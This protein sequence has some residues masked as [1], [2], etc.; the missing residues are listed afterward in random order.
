MSDNTGRAFSEGEIHQSMAAGLDM[1]IP[2]DVRP[3]TSPKVSGVVLAERRHVNPNAVAERT[4]FSE[5]EI[6]KGASVISRGAVTT[7]IP[8][9]RVYLPEKGAMIQDTVVQDAGSLSI[10]GQIS[11]TGHPP[12]AVMAARPAPSDDLGIGVAQPDLVVTPRQ[13]G[14]LA[15]AEHGVGVQEVSRLV[16]GPGDRAVRIQGAETLQEVT[17][18]SCPSPVFPPAA[19]APQPIAPASQPMPPAPQ[20]QQVPP[21][22]QRPPRQSVTLASPV[23]GRHRLKVDFV[24]VSASTVVLAYIDDEDATIFE[25]PLTAKDSPLEVLIGK[26]TYSC[27]YYGMSVTMEFGSYQ[28]FQVVLTRV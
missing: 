25:P 17:Q 24:G 11:G 19:I 18:L 21:R 20:I 23:L 13:A 15:A 26:D 8:V 12:G 27:A 14:K 2:A 4:A 22:M 5:G 7:E 6:P 28:V 10:S 9:Q 16:S 1:S 3:P